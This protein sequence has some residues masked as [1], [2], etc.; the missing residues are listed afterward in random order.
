[1]A[2]VWFWVRGGWLIG[3]LRDFMI[4]LS[5]MGMCYSISSYIE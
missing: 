4:P 5:A 2:E 3:W 1:M